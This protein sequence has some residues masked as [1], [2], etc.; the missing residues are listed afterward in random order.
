MRCPPWD[1]RRYSSATRVATVWV[2]LLAML[3]PTTISR[4]GGYS[5]AS[6]AAAGPIAVEIGS[7]SAATGVSP[8][9]ARRRRLNGDAAAI[10]LINC[11]NAEY[12]GTIGLGTPVQE[13][14][15]VVDTGS[16]TL[17]VRSEEYNR[18]VAVRTYA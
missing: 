13:F 15:V 2:T 9:Q 6:A 14:D 10:P 4:C 7:R 18:A 1:R 3:E 16:Y 17:W 5:R 8:A 11:E 12:S